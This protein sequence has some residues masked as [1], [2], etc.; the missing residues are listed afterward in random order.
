[1]SVAP[2]VRRPSYPKPG[3][4]A[5]WFEAFGGAWCF[6]SPRSSNVLRWISLLQIR[7]TALVG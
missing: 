3:D 2:V 4:F 7:E 6:F 5:A 1:M